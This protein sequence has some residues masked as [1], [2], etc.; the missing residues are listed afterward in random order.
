MREVLFIDSRNWVSTPLSR[1]SAMRP[2]RAVS[3][4]PGGRG[5]GGGRGCGGARLGMTRGSAFGRPPPNHPPP[6]RAAPCARP[7]LGSNPRPAPP[8]APTVGLQQVHDGAHLVLTAGRLQ[9]HG[10]RALGGRGRRGARATSPRRRTGRGRFLYGPQ[11]LRP[12]VLR[13]RKNMQSR[14]GHSGPFDGC[15]LWSRGAVGASWPHPPPS[16]APNPQPPRTTS[17]MDMRKI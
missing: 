3:R 16:T 14:P 12:G 13:C 9:H 5:R 2:V 1:D 15:L 6:S 10:G 17:M 7:L 4:M 11:G 8:P